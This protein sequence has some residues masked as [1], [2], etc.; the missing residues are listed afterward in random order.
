MNKMY[1][2]SRSVVVRIFLSACLL[3]S[4]SG[5]TWGQVST[6]SIQGTVRDSTGAVIPDASLVLHNTQTGVDLKNATNNAGEYA[7]VNIPP[8]RYDIRVKKDGFQSTQRRDFT[9]S[10]SQSST[11]DFTLQVGSSEQTVTISAEAPLLENATA[12][13]GTV[14]ASRQVNELPLNGRNFTQLL[15]LTPGASPINTAQTFGFRGVGNFAFPSFQG[16]RNRANLFLLDGVVNQGSITSN[17]A[18][19]PVVDDIQEFKVDSHNDQVQFGGVSGGVVNVVTKSGTNTVHGALWEYLRNSEFDARNPFFPAVNPLRQ[20]QFGG[21]AGGPVVVPGYNGRNRTFFFGSYEGFRNSIP[22]QTLGRIPTPDELKGQLGTISNTIYDPFST[23]PDPANPGQFL[24]DPFPGNNLPASI[25]DP[26]MTK[27]AQAMYPVP[28]QTSATGTNFARTAPSRTS[29]NQY[30]IRG[31][32]QLGEKNAFWF[33]YT[34]VTLPRV[35]TD[36]I[37]N[38]SN[39]DTWRARNIAASWTH[40]FGPGAVLQT[41]FGRTT[42]ADDVFVSVPATPS[43]LLQAL[44]PTF[45]CEFPGSRSCLLPAISLVGFLGSTGDQDT[46]QGA[47]DIW[48]GSANLSKLWGKHLFQ[49]GLSINTNNI[50]QSILYNNMNFSPFQTADLKNPGRTGSDLASYL[51]GVPVGGQ[52]RKQVGGENQGWVMGF[53]F[54]DKWN[55]TNRLTVNWGLRIDRTLPP[56]WGVTSDA[57]GYVGS[58][59]LN[60]GT[61][62]LQQRPPLCSATGKAPCIPGNDLPEHV[63][64]SQDGRIHRNRDFNLGPRLG[65]VYRLDSKT[66]IRT[67]GGIFYD[68]W[69]TWVQLGQSFGANWPSVNLLTTANLNPNVIT[70]RAS[71]PLSTIGAGALP[72]PTPFTQNVT[73]KDPFMKVPYTPEWNFGI[74]RQIGST[75]TLSVDY[76]GSHS[77]RLQLNFFANTAVTP[78]PGPQIDR[79]P[80]KYITPTN[81]ERSDGR[82][83]YHGLQVSVNRRVSHGLGFL[84]S[85]TWGKSIDISCSGWAGVEGCANQDPYNINA[86]R[87][88]SAFDITH[89]LTASALWE[90]PFGKGK[91]LSSG[92]STVNYLIGGWQLN[93]IMSF[94]SG[95]PYTLGVAGDIANTGNSNSSGFY[96]RLNLVGDPTL[97]DKTPAQWFNKSAFA[98]PAAF[99]YG[100]MGRNAMRAD[101]GKNVDLSLFRRF[102]IRERLLVE[103][104]AEA[105]NLTNT[106]VWGTPVNNYS[107]ANFG[108]VLNIAN[109][110][111]Q[112]QLGL[113]LG[114]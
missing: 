17:Y 64:V 63:V 55:A 81:Y 49:V 106:P 58:L 69:A 110:P 35:S 30:N 87:S 61:Y 95:V 21:N 54:G 45:A 108:R 83:V 98:V 75:T 86:D 70:V 111:R 2:P 76:V 9:L 40:T 99:T 84:T 27:L 20:N 34:N 14:I 104:R 3:A 97:A 23:R 67:S 96:E 92:N 29:Q 24:R 72:A 51:L 11:L 73:Y 113:R 114:F 59:N 46:H 91:M 43:G 41:Q 90:L 15:L 7:I 6:A 101:M 13:L 89:V 39:S 5:L 53:Y 93:T 68:N 26:N 12:E 1:M 52:R 62:I 4:L 66:V 18:V 65:L 37:G 10:V 74:Q 44:S 50:D 103:F 60:D 33:R 94:R 107:N 77:S 112:L 79:R 88:V 47:S 32:Q 19:P 48:S 31:D 22:I 80:I 36:P 78:A 85:Y 82:S 71:N 16:A 28:T 8:G 102:P 100:N 56:V 109:T 42:A 38:A 25:L 105:F 57:T